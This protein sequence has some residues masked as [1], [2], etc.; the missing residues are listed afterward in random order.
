MDSY[1]AL[2]KA[3]TLIM[4][5]FLR[6]QKKNSNEEGGAANSLDKQ[7]RMNMKV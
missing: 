2:K 7:Q 4:I 5:A 1:L 6:L 3:G